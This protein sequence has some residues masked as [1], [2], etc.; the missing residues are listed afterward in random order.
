MRG[1]EEL[2]EREGQRIFF[3]KGWV[4]PYTSTSYIYV[5]ITLFNEAR[6]IL[7]LMFAMVL[8]YG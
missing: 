6:F 1:E 2:R 7:S 8:H 4:Y 5:D 3:F